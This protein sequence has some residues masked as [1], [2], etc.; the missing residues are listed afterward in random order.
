[1][2]CIEPSGMLFVPTGVLTE[3][4]SLSKFSQETM[5]IPNVA[6]RT[7]LQGRNTKVAVVLIQ[8]KTPLPPGEDLVASEKAS[9]LCGSCDLSGKS[10]FV[11]PH[12]DHLVGY[13]IR[14]ENAFYEH[15]QTYYYTEIRR[16]KSHKEFLNK[17]THQVRSPANHT[18]GNGNPVPVTD[19]RIKCLS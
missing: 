8:K 18:V 6:P 16:V 1:M 11:L 9:A 3:S 19:G 10:L 7:S 5:S 2:L 13:I 12:T 14:L 17:T 4:P 15:A